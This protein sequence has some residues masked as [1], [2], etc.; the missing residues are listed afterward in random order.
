MVGQIDSQKKILL[1]KRITK[2]ILIKKRITK[3][4]VKLTQQSRVGHP[5]LVQEVVCASLTLVGRQAALLDLLN[6]I[7]PFEQL[8]AFVLSVAVIDNK[9][10]L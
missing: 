10:L 9:M 4:I 2:I 1:L 3:K 5:K 7:R 6:M 8:H